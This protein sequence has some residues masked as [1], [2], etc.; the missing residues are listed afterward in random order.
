MVLLPLVTRE[1]RRA[2]GKPATFWVRMAA[3]GLAMLVVLGLLS[4]SFRGITPPELLGG[5]VFQIVSIALLAY[6]LFAGIFLTADSLSSEKREGTMGLLFLTDLR[7]YDVVFGKLLAHSLN[8]FYAMVGT[9]PVLAVPMLLGGVT[10]DEF[11]RMVVT[12]VT[13]LLFSLSAGMMVSANLQGPRKAWIAT[14]LVISFVTFVPL[15]GMQVSLT[16]WPV[17]K[18]G[19]AVFSPAYAA[20]NA[21]DAIYIANP[22]DFWR[23]I[24]ALLLLTTAML[25]TA[26]II[27]PRSWQERP[28]SPLVARWRERWRTWTLGGESQRVNDRRQWL[29]VNPVLWLAHRER[30]RRAMLWAFV[31]I[32]FVLWLAAYSLFDDVVAEP[33]AIFLITAA[34]HLALKLW[35]ALEVSRRLA[36]DKRT[37]TL[38]LL[39]VTPLQVSE[40]LKGL[41]ASVRRQFMVPF[42]SVLVIDLFLL[43]FG[44]SSDRQDTGSLVAG[45]LASIGL[46]L[47]DAYTLTWVGFWEG[48][49]ARE[50]SRAFFS[51]I[52]KVLFLPWIYFC[53]FAGVIAVVCMGRL[54]PGGAWLAMAWFTVGYFNDAL[55]CSRAMFRTTAHFRFA[56]SELEK[57]RSL[58]LPENLPFFPLK[59][60]GVKVANAVPTQ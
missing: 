59:E 27:V 23:S 16:T 3:A 13:L 4:P 2:S 25:T 35:L 7:G 1:L 37:R 50:S 51:T 42:V 53:L 48:L 32:F 57:A 12:L 6:A 56:A 43:I 40:I 8:G 19:L 26:S 31:A 28:P 29:N 30:H 45:F 22:G 20:L 55:L 24:L 18:T 34:L 60:V 52:L 54:P 9:F 10:V 17:D 38:E 58:P 41:L 39:L 21:F 33:V 49:S 15:L 47:A 14:A 44:L 36:E 46:L 5:L 11:W